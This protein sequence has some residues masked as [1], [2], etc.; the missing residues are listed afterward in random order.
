MMSRLLWQLMS[1]LP[2]AAGFPRLKKGQSKGHRG[3]IAVTAQWLSS[4]NCNWNRIIPSFVCPHCHF[5]SVLKMQGL[6]SRVQAQTTAGRACLSSRPVLGSRP[7]ATIPHNPHRLAQH[8]RAG[9]ARGAAQQALGGAPQRLWT[10]RASIVAMAAA[11]ASSHDL[12]IVGPGVLGSYAGKLWK[13]SFPD[14]TVVAQT[15]TTGSHD[16]CVGVVFRGSW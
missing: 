14:A 6:R 11:G 16:R 4:F 13:E 2:Y 12:L 3:E 15:N 8:L 7:L 1:A 9:H 5:A 10:R